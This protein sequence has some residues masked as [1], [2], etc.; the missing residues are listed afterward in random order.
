MLKWQPVSGDER[1]MSSFDEWFKRATGNDPYPFQVR[2]AC[3]P[4]L[5]S[6]PSPSG[7]GQGEGLLM[8]VPTGL[9]KTAVALDVQSTVLC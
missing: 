8:D 1:P 3:E 6:T 7:R 5:L 9:G 2:F 4:G